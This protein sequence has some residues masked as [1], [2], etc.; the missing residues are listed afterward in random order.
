MKLNN[1][2]IALLIISL[3][4]L[5][6]CNEKKTQ[7]EVTETPVEVT[8]EETAEFDLIDDNG[9]PII[10]GI[11]ER[12]T[13]EKEPYKKWFDESYKEHILDTATVAAIKNDLAEATITV[14]MGT[15]CE[16]SQREIPAFYKVLDLARID[17]GTVKLITITEGKDA[18]EELIK[19]NDIEYVPTIIFEKHGKELGRIVEYTIFS[20][21]KDIEKILTG[22]GYKHPYAE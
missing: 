6:S 2:F 20:M 15:W 22:D 10:V 13:L 19:E 8:P 16:D 1:T 4:A 18:P 14:F 5:T 9:D 7:T 12:A 17:A 21:E 11:Q 3:F